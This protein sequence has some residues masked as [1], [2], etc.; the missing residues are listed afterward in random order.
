MLFLALYLTYFSNCY[1]ISLYI[2]LLVSFVNS[3]RSIPS[4]ISNQKS[5]HNIIIH[6][7][8]NNNPILNI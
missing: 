4:S 6:A 3:E 7:L 1:L 2:N 5:K 8:T